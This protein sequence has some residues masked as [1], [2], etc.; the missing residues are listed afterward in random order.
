MCSFQGD[1]RKWK[2]QHIWYSAKYLLAGNLYLEYQLLEVLQMERWVSGCYFESLK[3]VFCTS[4]TLSLGVTL[5]PLNGCFA[6][7]IP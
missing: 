1:T 2:D 4:Y 3:W 7:V 5:N 6:L